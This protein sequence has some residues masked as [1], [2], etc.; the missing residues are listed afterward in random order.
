[1]SGAVR[2]ARPA[3]CVS[4]QSLLTARARTAAGDACNHDSLRPARREGGTWRPSAAPPVGRRLGSWFLTDPSF[5]PSFRARQR[6]QALV[7]DGQVSM[8]NTVV[9]PNARK[10][11]RLG[12]DIVVGFAGATA[13]AL[14]LLERLERKLDEYPGMVAAVGAGR[15]WKALLT[16]IASRCACPPPQASC[17]APASSWQRPGGLKS[18]F[19]GSRC[20]AARCCDDDATSPD[21]ALLASAAGHHDRLGQERVAP[22]YRKRRR[23]RAGG[24]RHRCVA[25]AEAGAAGAADPCF[26]AS[27]A[28]QPSGRAGRLRSVRVHYCYRR[29]RW[30]RRSPPPPPPCAQL[31]RVR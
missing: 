13:D 4:P 27:A 20:A 28:A 29:V 23:A 14:T 17:C 9:K 3:H 5:F 7:G 19:A 16:R 6:R 18:T 8:G 24:R 10:I 11:R 25:C 21:P 15:R 2:G 1:M 22:D 30:L 31:R 12:D 26:A